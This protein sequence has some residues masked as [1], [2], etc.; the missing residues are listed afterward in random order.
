MSLTE[1]LGNAE[2]MKA[3][4]D[5]IKALLPETWTHLANLEGEPMMRVAFRLK[6]LGIDW[7]SPDEFGKCM[8]YFERV[9][10]LKRDGVLVRRAA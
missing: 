5:D 4:A 9:G 2:W 7:R 8:V 1:T 6:L 3:H 10:L